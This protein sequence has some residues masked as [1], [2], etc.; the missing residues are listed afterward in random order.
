[1]LW[2]LLLALPVVELCVC[3]VARLVKDASGGVARCAIKL[4]RGTRSSHAACTPCAHIRCV[5]AVHVTTGHAGRLPVHVGHAMRRDFPVAFIRGSASASRRFTDMVF[6]L[7]RTTHLRMSLTAT[8]RR[9]L[10]HAG[11][12]TNARCAIIVSPSCH[13][14]ARPEPTGWPIDLAHGSSFR[15]HFTI[16]RASH[17]PC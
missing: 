16:V 3:D 12:G 13:T 1:M 4:P 9:A 2:L 8:L 6:P 7:H 15:I 5:H 17:L 11:M 14:V 10:P